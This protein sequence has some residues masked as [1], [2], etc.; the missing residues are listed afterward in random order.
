MKKILLTLSITSLLSTS[1]FAGWQDSDWHEP[2]IGC[3]AIGGFMY[4]GKSE[5]STSEK[6]QSALIGC[7]VG[8]LA[9]H[10]LNTYYS[11][12][13]GVAT[14]GDMQKLKGHLKGYQMRSA[15]SNLS[16]NPTG[17]FIKPELVPAK[18]NLDG[19]FT[20]ETYKFKIVVPGEGLSLDD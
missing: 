4:M 13:D 11:A 5:G 8:G 16:G 12:K 14:Q 15:L 7:A 17:G 2:S 19:S 18:K 10:L 9:G 3:A 20:G 6:L 1:A